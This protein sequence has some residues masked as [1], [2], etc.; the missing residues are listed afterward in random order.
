MTKGN[1]IMTVCG[2]TLMVLFYFIG[3]YSQI[4]NFTMTLEDV[5]WITMLSIPVIAGIMF[6]NDWKHDDY[7]E[8]LE[9]RIDKLEKKIGDII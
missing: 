5:F 2:L 3:Y 1:K 8:Q 9:K 7:I 4:E 6:A